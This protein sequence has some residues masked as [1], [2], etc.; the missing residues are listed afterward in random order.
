MDLTKLQHIRAAA[1]HGCL[2]EGL[3]RKEIAEY[4]ADVVADYDDLV[5]SCTHTEALRR[6][7]RPLLALKRTQPPMT[8]ARARVIIRQA[9]DE[10][11]I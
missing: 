5:K 6:T 3:T 11:L 4:S 9:E 10:G 8:M 7:R 2:S 1:M